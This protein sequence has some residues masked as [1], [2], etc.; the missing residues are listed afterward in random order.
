MPTLDDID[1]DRWSMD[2]NACGGVR[3]STLSSLEAQM[4]KLLSLDQM[5][6]VN[7]LGKPDQNELSRR[8]EKFFYYFI[9]PAP[10]CAGAA[11]S[12][13]RLEV[14]F[15]AVGLAKEVMIIDGE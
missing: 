8:N 4:D 1:T 13:R 2:K 12:P 11:V 7:L 9:D 15:N 3:A 10:V 6:I 5:Q 14:R